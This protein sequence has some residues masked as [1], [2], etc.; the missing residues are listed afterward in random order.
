MISKNTNRL[1]TSAVRKAPDSP[2]SCNWNNRME[3]A[4]R[5][6]PAR[7]GVQHRR[8]P[9]Q[10]GQQQHHG[11]RGGRHQHDAVGHRAS[12][13]G[14]RRS[15][16]RAVA[17]ATAGRQRDGEAVRAVAASTLSTRVAV[18]V[19]PS[20]I[21][22]APPQRKH[23]RRDQVRH[24]R[25]RRSMDD[26]SGAARHCVERAPVVDRPA[27]HVVVVGQ[28]ARASSTTGTAPWWRSRSRWRSAR[29]PAASGP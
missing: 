13:E 22:T 3:M 18:G 5:P 15:S 14:R 9:Q 6:V 28:P 20:A 2:I 4:R 17:A 11:R 1:N 19:S 10:A 24:Q 16:R 21:I 29:A 26:A 12:S 8:Q 23:D 25:G 27:V 7:T